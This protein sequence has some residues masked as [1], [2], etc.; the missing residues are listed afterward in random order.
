MRNLLFILAIIISSNLALPF[1]ISANNLLVD[2]HRDYLLFSIRNHYYIMN[3]DS[4]Y[5]SCDEVNW[6][7]IK[8]PIEAD[9]FNKLGF[10]GNDEFGYIHFQSGGN[11]YL[12]KDDTIKALSNGYEL[13]S[14]Y[15]SAPFLTNDE[16]N[17][18]GGYG[19][20]EY[21]NDIIYFDNKKKEWEKKIPVNKESDL[22]ARRSTHF[23]IADS[24]DLYICGGIS[25]D[26]KKLSSYSFTEIANDVWKYNFI[27][28]SWK[29][30]GKL[31]NTF[32]SSEYK[33]IRH[34]KEILLIN[35]NK[36]GLNRGFELIFLDLKENKET[37]YKQNNIGFISD[38]IVLNGKAI[39]Y[40]SYT[41]KFFLLINKE[42]NKSVPL[43]LKDDEFLG[44]KTYEDKAYSSIEN[45]YYLFLILF[46]LI[47]GVA[48]YFLLLRKK[49]TG[50]ED[51]I[52][53]IKKLEDQNS[54]DL[55]SEEY[56]ILQTILAEF[57]EPT[58]YAILL[59]CFDQSYGYESQIKKLR[60]A[61]ANIN[62]QLKQVLKLKNDI[63]IQQRNNFD[64]RIKE[65]IFDPSIIN[66]SDRTLK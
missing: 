55:S 12:I 11:V 30:L 59:N 8:N 44:D 6:K 10:I 7:S 3:K 37:R 43:F 63:L 23:H 33:S 65:I 58:S 36:E 13:R 19:V 51:L 66:Q 28:N 45:L 54:K 15:S 48:S 38:A 49:K 35:N 56:K 40:N 27:N 50:S 41:D 64:R 9:N 57:P 60:T 25:I 14:H 16:L 20:F 26:P 62:K 52:D 32:N 61:I 47:L 34:N 2:T 46:I 22:P 53:K 18:F 1:T 29:K 5:I 31:H 24:S 39:N 21:R 17:L 42:A 4:I